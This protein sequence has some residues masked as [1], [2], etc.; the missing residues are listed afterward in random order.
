MDEVDVRVVRELFADARATH[1]ELGRAVGLS[2]NAVAARL[3]RMEK[4]G[5]LQGFAAFPQPR[6]LGMVEGLLVFSH[7]DDIAER[8]ADLL[9]SLP[10]LPGVRFVDV[11]LDQSVH[12]WL[13]YASEAD[14]ERVERAAVSLV[15]KPP[16]LALRGDAREPSALAPADWRLVRALAP[17][18]RAPVKALARAAGLS[19]KTAKRR[20]AAL[21]DAGALRLEPVLSP[22]EADGLV[23]YTLGVVLKPD[24]RPEDVL[25]ALPDAAVAQSAPGAPLV[26]YHAARRT[27]REAQA[28]HRRVRA[29]PG[30]ERALFTIATRRRADGWLADAIDARLAQLAPTAPRPSPAAPTVPVPVPR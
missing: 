17:D 1:E 5:V 12:V 13:C 6:L 25:A 30:V 7:V 19:F 14:W 11:G 9:A 3:R 2:A 29:L 18:A 26:L 21:L 15:G 28:D 22:S 27:A 23:L 20:L 16:A 10:E 24:A 4:S 8:E